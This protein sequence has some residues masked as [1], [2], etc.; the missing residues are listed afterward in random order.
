MGGA[1]SD[2]PTG[3]TTPRYGPDVCAA[4]FASAAD[5]GESGSTGD[6]VTDA[7]EAIDGAAAREEREAL[8]PHD[9]EGSEGRG[10]DEAR[11]LTQ[12]FF[13]RVLAADGFAHALKRYE[14]NRLP[15]A[16]EIQQTSSKNTWM[17]NATDPTWVYGYDVWTAP[18][19]DSA[20]AT[21]TK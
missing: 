1:A 10:E 7:V 13:R 8:L 18:L 19:I 16:S 2:E 9:G 12:E 3:P 15:R 5:T 17:R 21:A 14:A 6:A 11:D 4:G 20:S